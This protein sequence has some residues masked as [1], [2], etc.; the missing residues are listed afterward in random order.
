MVSPTS[1]ETLDH[2]LL[3]ENQPHLLVNFDG[4]FLLIHESCAFLPEE[5]LG[6]EYR[7][8]RLLPDSLER[9]GAAIRTHSTILGF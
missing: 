2:K 8:L 3:C 7:C 6:L 5:Q 9:L 4:S 1:S